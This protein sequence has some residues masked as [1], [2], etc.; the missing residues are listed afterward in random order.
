M[1]VILFI[2]LLVFLIALLHYAVY[3]K[4]QLRS[5]RVENKLFYMLM[6]REGMIRR[7]ESYPHCRNFRAVRE[8]N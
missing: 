8:K 7:E 2:I 5:V 3:L 1:F 4:K 6:C